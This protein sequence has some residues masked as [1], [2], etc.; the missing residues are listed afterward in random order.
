[1]THCNPIDLKMDTTTCA[2]AQPTILLSSLAGIGQALKS[3]V[4]TQIQRRVDRRR[5]RTLKDLD[6]D[7]LADIGVTRSEVNQV[8]E[9]PLSVDAATELQQMSLTRRRKEFNGELP[10]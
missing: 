6:D 10:R 5:L 4:C 8:S 3:F 2:P 1:M 9:L 7:M